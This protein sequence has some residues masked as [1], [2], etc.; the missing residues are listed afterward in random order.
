MNTVNPFNRY[1][2]MYTP[3]GIMVYDLISV[4]NGPSEFAFFIKDE[5]PYIF[6][7]K[8]PLIEV[9]MGILQFKKVYVVPMMVMVNFDNDMLYETMF[10]YHQS[11]GG[12]MFLEALINQ[13][14]I[15]L[16]FCDEFNKEVRRIRIDNN[17]KEDATSILNILQKSEAWSMKEFDEVK[18]QLYEQ[19]PTN[20][21]LWRALS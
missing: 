11:S 9:R 1:A 8:K 18:E 15:K 19:F 13:D 14:N 6:K 17:F 5:T 7:H 21:D 4:D 20:H 2:N 12:D 3:P 16:F 10:N